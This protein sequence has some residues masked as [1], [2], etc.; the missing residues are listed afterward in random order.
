MLASDVLLVQAVQQTQ[1]AVQ[2]ARLVL[3]GAHEAEGLREE[4]HAAASSLC[5]LHMHKM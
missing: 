2:A 4:E 5:L 3:T 1:A